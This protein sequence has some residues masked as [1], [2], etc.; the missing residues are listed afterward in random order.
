MDATTAPRFV[1]GG[2]APP[3]LDARRPGA[4]LRVASAVLGAWLSLS[5]F[6][7]P[8][9][10]TAGFNDFMVGI[11]AF[12]IALCAIWAPTL[13]FGN[14]MLA[15]WLLVTTTFF[16]HDVAL[17]AWVDALTAIA[18]FALSLVPSWPAQLPMPET[19]P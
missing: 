10:P 8:H 17:T 6:L 9:R 3:R 16:G 13:R 5:V 11:F 4:P 12:V 1:D 14:T 15:V 18:L 19:T 7:W 2:T